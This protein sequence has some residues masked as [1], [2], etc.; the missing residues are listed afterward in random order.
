MLAMPWRSEARP[1]DAM[2]NDDFAGLVRRSAGRA[3]LEVSVL[4]SQ[5]VAIG[6]EVAERFRDGSV[7]LVG[8]AAHRTAPTG[9]TGMNTAIQ[10]AHNLAWTLAAVIASSVL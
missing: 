9:A 1:V 8:D 10:S 7:F 3:D 2:T 4:G 6:A 5:L